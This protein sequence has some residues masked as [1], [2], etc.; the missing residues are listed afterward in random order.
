MENEKLNYQDVVFSFT[1]NILKEGVVAYSAYVASAL[2]GASEQPVD[3]TSLMLTDDEGDFIQRELECAFYNILEVLSAYHSPEMTKPD[4]STYRFILRLPD[5]RKPHIDGLISHELQRTFVSWV[6]SVWYGNR[7]P[8]EA[9]RQRQLYD[10]AIAT[11]KHD[12]LVARGGV[13]RGCSYL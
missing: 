13:R 10:A 1:H 5:S 9:A 6:L 7:L 3:V 11:A 2:H 4:G 8:H 12:V